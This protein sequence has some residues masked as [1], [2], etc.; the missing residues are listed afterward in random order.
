MVLSRLSKRKKV[1]VWYFIRRVPQQYQY[2][3]PRT[4]IQQS[5]GVRISDDPR[6]NGAARHAA[7]AMDAA[8]EIYWRGLATEGPKKALADYQAATNA[9]KKLDVSPPLQ[10]KNERTIV[11]LLERIEMLE[12][13]KVAEDTNNVAALL[14][15]APSPKLTFQQC[16]EQ[17]IA[18][19]KNGWSNAKHAAQWSTSL[20]Q[21]AYP[22]IG[23]IPVAQLSGHTGT[24]KI[25]SLLDPIW[26][27]KT[28]TA[29]R[30]R[31]RIE[32]VLDWAKAQGFRDGEN[33]ARWTGHLDV[34]YPGKEK[35]APTKHHVA[36]PFRDV[37]GFMDKLRD[38]TGIGARALEFVILTA[39]RTSEVLQAKR[40]EID[41]EGRMWIVPKDRMKMR[42]E[43][44]IPLCD[45]ALEII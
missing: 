26:H 24:H 12:R 10:D 13:G 6:G 3:D 27:V 31:G 32:K 41:R 16:A 17:Y 44:R 37:P 30:V 40:S 15:D 34:I 20:E 43:H 1:G 23:T 18:S 45:R 14:D 4:I 9:A 2:L 5:T 35:A 38:Q 29:H 8:L 42:R 22:F 28:T 36:M 21:F 7:D 33:P 25:K 11:E 39:S 19:H